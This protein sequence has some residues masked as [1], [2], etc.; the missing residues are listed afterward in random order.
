MWEQLVSLIQE[1][2]QQSVVN[3]PEVPNEKNGQIIDEAKNVISSKFSDLLSSGQI[4]KITELLSGGADHPEAK[5]M[6]NNFAASIMQKFGISNQV[7]IGIATTLI[8]AVL[9]AIRGK[10]GEGG[11]NVQDIL[12]SLGGGGNLQ[13]TLSGLGAKLGLDKDGDGDVDLGDLGKMFKF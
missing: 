7:A 8:P 6:E 13:S 1:H 10:A 9:N 4:G 3:N 2:S 12:A 5:D 11:F